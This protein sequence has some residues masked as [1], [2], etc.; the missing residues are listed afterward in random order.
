MATKD[1]E[2][3]TRREFLKRAALVGTGFAAGLN[4]FSRIEAK[5]ESLFVKLDDNNY[6][7]EIFN[8]NGPA[9][10]MF[11]DGDFKR[12]P[13][14][15]NM[16]EVFKTL[17]KEYGGKPI[18]RFDGKPIKFGIFD[19]APIQDLPVAKKE[20]YKKVEKYGQLLTFPTTIMY[21][22][23]ER[24]DMLRGA[25]KDERY[26]NEWI[27]F[28]RDEWVPTNIT[29]PNGRF[30]WR[31]NNTWNEVKVPYASPKF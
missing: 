5:A 25:P 3:L 29:K 10:V 24:I 6:Q 26:I 21:I 15:G 11:Y 4:P 1:L 14:S 8:Y 30:Y 20:K 28:L 19:I 22:N 12:A 27:H 9:L 13:P 31:F 18:D 17:A 2:G 7:E 23:G 16:F